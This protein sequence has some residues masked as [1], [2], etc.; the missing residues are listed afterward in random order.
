MSLLSVTRGE[1]VNNSP[2]QLVQSHHISEHISISKIAVGVEV[3]S[4]ET[5][6]LLHSMNWYENANLT[7][8]VP[9]CFRQIFPDTFS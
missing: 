2:A 3:T 8:H 4:K 7:W 1:I 5:Q 6:A 9:G